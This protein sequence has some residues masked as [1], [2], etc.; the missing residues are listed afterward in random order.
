MNQKLV[1]INTVG[2]TGGGVTMETSLPPPPPTIKLSKYSSRGAATSTSSPLTVAETSEYGERVALPGFLT[3]IV[4][5]VQ[6]L[7]ATAR[8]GAREG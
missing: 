1:H 2:W 3:A 8:V 6:V 5:D 7:L 4:S